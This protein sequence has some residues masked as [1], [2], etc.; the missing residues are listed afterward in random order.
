MGVVHLPSPFWTWGRSF[1]YKIQPSLRRKVI[2]I[3]EHPTQV[4]DRQYFRSVYFRTP[5]GV[6]FEIATDDPGFTFDE[7]VD[8]LGGS[9]RLPRWMETRRTEIEA[10]LPSI[11]RTM[12]QVTEVSGDG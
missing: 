1:R 2:E 4:I 5:G 9:L 6:L 7:S 12:P 10:A 8:Q 3:G 11:R